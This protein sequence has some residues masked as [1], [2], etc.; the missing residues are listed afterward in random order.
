MGLR[1][2]R[3]K[4]APGN[5]QGCQGDRGLRYRIRTGGVHYGVALH[6]RVAVLLVDSSR[7]PAGKSDV[8]GAQDGLT[9]DGFHIVARNKHILFRRQGGREIGYIRLRVRVAAIGFR[10]KRRIVLALPHH[11]VSGGRI[12][13]HLG[14]RR[15]RLLAGH[16]LVAGQQ[17][18]VRVIG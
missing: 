15:E 4:C 12:C 5:S 7:L 2:G 11:L 14:Q 10:R 1:D 13:S 17:H 8:A 9:V 18:R 6:V 3:G 16:G